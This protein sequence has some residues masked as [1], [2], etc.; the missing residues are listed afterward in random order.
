VKAP[1]VSTPSIAEPVLV[2]TKLHVP[3]L[4]AELV[5][6][7]ELV[8]RLV[9][10]RERKLTL[11]CAPA[12]WG[13]STLLSEW[14]GWADEARPFAWL[15]LDESDHD[16]VRFWSYVIGALRS[17]QPDLGTAPLVAL[18]SAGRDLV[19]V[20]VA[21]LINELAARSEPLVLVLDDYHLLGSSAIDA[22]L[23][24][25]LRHLPPT[26]HIAISSRADPAL[27]LGAL[28]AAGQ[29]TEIG[30]ADLRFS[31]TEAEELLNG[32][33]GLGLDPADVG[34]LQARTEGWAAGL[35]L[36]AL[37]ARTVDDRHA[38]VED[39]AGS[40]RLIGDY[41]RELLADQPSSL[42]DFLLETSILER[43]CA[44]LSDAVTGRGDGAEQLEAADRSNLF[45]VSLD[46]RAEWFRYHPLFHDLLRAELARRGPE[47][48]NELH[49]R[50]AAWHR[51][52]GNAD[53]A[54]HHATAAGDFRDASDL[55]ARHW[56][57]AWN[58]GQRE[59]VGS[60]VDALPSDA[61]LD[62]ARLCIARGW[63]ALFLG[64]FGE[65]EQWA[66]AAELAPLP[67]PFFDG[68]VSVPAVVARLRAV[69]AYFAGDVR[70]GIEQGRLAVTLSQK[71]DPEVY[72]PACVAL[73]VN[74]SFGG[75]TK[76]A[77]GLLEAALPSLV[78]PRWVDARLAALGR[79]TSILA[80]GGQIERA[81]RAAAEAEWL[82]DEL[83]LHEL[84][85]TGILHAGRG[86]LL[87]LRGEADAAAAGYRRAITLARRGERRLDLAL[88]LLALARL[89]RGR[90]HAEARSL[91][92]EARAVLSL[93][94]DPGRLRQ[95]LE[96]A[97]RS[98]QL[99][100]TRRRATELAAEVDLSER[101]LTV[102]RLLASDLSQREIG[103]ELYV[104]FN[105]VKA[106]TRSIFRKLGVSARADAVA[107]GR[108]LGLL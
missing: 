72:G 17:V 25:L 31:D 12:G 53:E 44:P 43:L 50:A 90:R 9:A 103:S 56:G 34:L 52:H 60:W 62:D 79:L 73:G 28:R 91:T 23:A 102:L 74:L 19:D 63:T 77:A 42:R 98:L 83:A 8:E 2:A 99:T 46:S 6:R 49:R 104:S 38:F 80:E 18:R 66:R 59:T 69:H 61:V 97:E 75:D 36:A 67:G 76:E 106:H 107:R 58:L 11:V 81:E 95:L 88:A 14:A 27:P 33:L 3:A 51:A 92:R 4:R 82:V 86:Q 47:L 100:A 85:T 105:T 65:V 39:F 41:L 15:S 45:V 13:K 40:D 10:E 21:P 54:I 84:A 16:P 108:E 101:E 71:E 94:P 35:Q 20:V 55:I 89:E 87:E 30:A 48:V 7:R 22:S 24:F 64:A 1:A 96:N 5:P 32:S 93:C 68:S 57:P 37:S 78:P 70:L 29:M 26:L